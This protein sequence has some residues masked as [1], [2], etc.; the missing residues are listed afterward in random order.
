MAL[1]KRPA[2]LTSVQGAVQVD[3]GRRR[4]CLAFYRDAAKD[5]AFGKVFRLEKQEQE[6]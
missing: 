5:S 1:K 6:A 4:E 3:C 2:P